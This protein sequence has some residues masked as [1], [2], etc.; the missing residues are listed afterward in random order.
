MT[1]LH[2]HILPGIDDGAKTVEESVALL[3]QELEQGVQ[4]FVFT[5]HFNPECIDVEAF[6]KKRA[7]AF[8]LLQKAVQEKGL[9]IQ[10]KLGA[11]VQF[12]SML[13]ELDL[14]PLLIEKTPYLLIELSPS[15][16][17]PWIK[18]VFYQLQLQGIVPILAHVER[19]GYLMHNPREL[20]DLVSEGVIIQINASS[21]VRKCKR[22][23]MLK[24]F[25]QL[26]L[27]HIISTDTHS[28]DK[29]PP[30]ME[31]AFQQ[32]EKWHG[33]DKVCALQKNGAA[34]FAGETL[35]LTDAVCP[36]KI[37]GQW[38]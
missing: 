16:Y 26:N 2:C 10:M 21:I 34:V 17:P 30:L 13:S 33:N 6:K 32:I 37:L 3:R 31:P 9:S 15:F 25:L 5:P 11:E 20:F 12:S 7:E 22:Q 1:D 28:I 14:T 24:K 35:Q 27:V 38:L 18:D 23:K 4:Q 36:R 19:Y 8:E 29:R